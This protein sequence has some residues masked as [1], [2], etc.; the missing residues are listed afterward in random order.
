M[1]SALQAYADRIEELLVTASEQDLRDLVR[2]HL[3]AMRGMQYSI[4]RLK[5]ENERLRNG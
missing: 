1:T 4:D 5:L 3:S 2:M